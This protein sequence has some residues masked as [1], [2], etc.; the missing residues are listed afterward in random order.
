MITYAA[1]RQAFRTRLL[2]V[3][4]LPLARAWENRAFAPPSPPANWVRETLLP[5]SERRSA[6]NVVEAVGLMQY[7]F[8]TPAAQGTE[9]LETLVDAVRLVFKPTT[10]LTAD[11]LVDRAERGTATQ[12]PDWFH[13]P[14]RLRWRAYSVNA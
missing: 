1:I 9:A 8:F 3:P 7:D 12:E 4:G 10:G 6:A 5:V 11:L 2:T 14:V 13:I